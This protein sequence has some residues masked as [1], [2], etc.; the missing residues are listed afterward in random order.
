MKAYAENMKNKNHKYNKAFGFV[1]WKIVTK[2]QHINLVKDIFLYVN[3]QSLMP[4][5]PKNKMKLN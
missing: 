2:N 5:T 4:S 1:D 3:T